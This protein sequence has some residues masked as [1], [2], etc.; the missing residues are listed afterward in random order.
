MSSNI[1]NCDCALGLGLEPLRVRV[2]VRGLEQTTQNQP[3]R[4]KEVKATSEY[5]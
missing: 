3:P 1:L 5:L 4:S 2:R